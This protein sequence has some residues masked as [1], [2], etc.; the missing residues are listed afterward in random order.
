MKFSKFAVAALAAIPLLAGPALAEDRG[1]GERHE[2]HRSERWHGDIHRFRDHDFGVWRGGHWNHGPHLGRFG[3]WW[4]VG[5][6]WYYYPAPVYPY[7][8]PYRPPV[9]VVPPAPAA[10]AYWYY[11]RNPAGYYPY[12]PDCPSGWLPQP[13]TVAPPP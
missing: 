5:G 11:C 7:P 6:A 10:P 8:D 2:F 1:R 12:V 13:A 3:W 9:A 4:I